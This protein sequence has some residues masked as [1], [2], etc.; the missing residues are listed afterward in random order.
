MGAQDFDGTTPVSVTITGTSAT[1]A[2]ANLCYDGTADPLT[3][4]TI[5]FNAPELEGWV[6]SGGDV[7]GDNFPVSPFVQSGPG[8]PGDTLWTVTFNGLPGLT[9][10]SGLQLQ[11]FGLPDGQALSVA[12]G[13]VPEA[14]TLLLSL[15]GLAPLAWFGRKFRN[16]SQSSS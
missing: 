4:L 10:D 3:I 9:P 8:L 13:P 12:V 16:S 14:G 6:F 5:S 15:L 1:E 11:T 7:F 2:F